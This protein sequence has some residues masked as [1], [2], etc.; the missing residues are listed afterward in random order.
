[1]ARDTFCPIRYTISENYIVLTCVLCQMNLSFRF[2]VG[3]YACSG[4]LSEKHRDK[5]HDK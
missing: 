1:M 3:R 5:N 4:H 2:S